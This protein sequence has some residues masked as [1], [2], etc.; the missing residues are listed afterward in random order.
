MRWIESGIVNRRACLHLQRNHS[1]PGRKGIIFF[2]VN[3]RPLAHFRGE[4]C[5]WQ[6]H[7]QGR[8]EFFVIRLADIGPTARQD[9][10]R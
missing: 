9:V 10:V 7:H 5:D 4:F 8:L 3:R 2:V 1:R 6:A